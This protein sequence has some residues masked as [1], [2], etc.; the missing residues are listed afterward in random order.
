MFTDEEN[1][2]LLEPKSNGRY[3]A[4]HRYLTYAASPATFIYERTPNTSLILDFGPT[5]GDELYDIYVR[6]G[7]YKLD[8]KNQ[9]I[10][11]LN[12]VLYYWNR[13]LLQLNSIVDSLANPREFK[14]SRPDIANLLS[15]GSEILALGATA[16]LWTLTTV[17]A[18]GIS[19]TMIGAL[20]GA[21][22]TVIPIIGAV[23][24]V[25]SIVQG[26]INRSVAQAIQNRSLENIND[27]QK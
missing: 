14:S 21:L 2:I 10:E 4:L 16:G 3:Y 25:G 17:T 24:L 1:K 20:A 15:T 9:I 27:L 18:S 13:E 19:V 12:L 23:A 22:A 7:Y 26:I 8:E 6:D 11:D 5:L